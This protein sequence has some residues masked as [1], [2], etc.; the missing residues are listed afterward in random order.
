MSHYECGNLFRASESLLIKSGLVRYCG[1]S[2]CCIESEDKFEQYWKEKFHPE[3]GRYMA[4]VWFSIGA[5][6]L[7]KA[8]L[9]CSGLVKRKTESLGY[10]FYSAKNDKSDWIDCVLHP[11][12]S[13]WG[14]KEARK[15]E[16]GSLGQLIP[17]FG[18]LNHIQESEKKKSEGSL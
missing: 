10:P 3:F 14:E 2:F 16:Y 9:V 12:K 18:K 15:Y 7:A 17:K 11:Q 13:N 1:E 5:E 8:S 6:N 4:W